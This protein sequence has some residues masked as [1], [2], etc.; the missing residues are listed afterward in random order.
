MLS[1]G[2]RH[3]DLKYLHIFT[4]HEQVLLFI[5]MVIRQVY[6]LNLKYP[7]SHESSEVEYLRGRIKD[8]TFFFF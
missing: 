5:E 6:N 7:T 4:Y 1:V 2:I 8:I 3:E